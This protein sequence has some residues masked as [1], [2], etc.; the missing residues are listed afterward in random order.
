MR[1]GRRDGGIVGFEN[2][3]PARHDRDEHRSSGSRRDWDSGSEWGSRGSASL[4]LRS[5]RKPKEFRPKSPSRGED[6]RV[7]A[8]GQG[9]CERMEAITGIGIPTVDEEEEI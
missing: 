1:A 8:L 2:K 6:G 4:R 3:Q 9:Q 7:L 5:S